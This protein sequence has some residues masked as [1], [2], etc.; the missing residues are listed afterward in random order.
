MARDGVNLPKPPFFTN[1]PPGARIE[2]SAIKYDLQK[3]PDVRLLLGSFRKLLILLPVLL[4][5][6][7]GRSQGQSTPVDIYTN[8]LGDWVGYDDTTLDGI[9][10]H[11]AVEVMITRKKDSVQMDY[12]YS[13]PGQPDFSTVT[14]FM[15]LDPL[16]SEMTLRWKGLVQGGSKY[17]AK[18][19]DEFARTG[20]GTFTATGAAVGPGG[21]KGMFVFDLGP[22]TMSY[23]WLSETALGSYATDTTFS[24]HRLGQNTSK[25]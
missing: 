12:T 13:K 2:P 10:K 7:S 14:K 19:L 21:G 1:P 23:K 22:E 8:L 18:D 25:Q 4:T 20:F 16:R 11:I 24:L 17:K 9:A 5:G 3:D 6:L 15:K